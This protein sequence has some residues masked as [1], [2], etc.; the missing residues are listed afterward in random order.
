MAR[1]NGSCLCGE[2]RWEVEGRPRFAANCHCTMCR[3]QH[4]AAFATYGAVARTKLRITG[5]PKRFRS[6]PDA[7]RSF[8]GTC[9][10]SLFFEYDADPKTTWISLGTADCDP[11]CRP[12]AN[13]YVA[14]KA[15]WVEL[16]DGLPQY[17]E[18]AP[19]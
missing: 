10:S 4:G 18:H 16:T 13:V 2:I 7:V 15:P 11:N 17:A 6:S 19:R 3:K 8:C 1:T 9:G 14:S 5:E 12:E